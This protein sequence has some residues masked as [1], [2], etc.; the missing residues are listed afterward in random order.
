MR[1]ATRDDLDALVEVHWAVAAEGRWLGTE[2][3]FDRPAKRRSM[4]ETVE[5]PQ[6]TMLVADAADEGVVGYL[7]VHLAPYGVAEVGMA[8]VQ[9]WRGK[10]LGAALLKS[11]IDWA[12]EAGAHKMA[13]EVWPDNEAAIALYR[14]AG[15]VEEGRKRRHYRRANGEL[16]DAVLMGRALGRDDS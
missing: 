16:W 9:D 1:A 3:P 2:T 13:L 4:A 15:F 7:S 6:A 12:V 8:L 10:G 5:S 14:K 11:A